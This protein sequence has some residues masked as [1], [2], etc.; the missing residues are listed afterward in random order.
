MQ[1]RPLM[2]QMYRMAQTVNVRP[3]EFLG[4]E[5]PYVAY[6]CDEAVIAFGLGVETQVDAVEAKNDKEL[7][8][9]R[10]Q[11]LDRLLGVEPVKRFKAFRPR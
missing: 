8:R 5:D 1:N 2:W 4:I 6:C 7:S 3:S 10:Q 9:K 11:V